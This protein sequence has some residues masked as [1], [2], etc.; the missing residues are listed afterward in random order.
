M[1]AEQIEFRMDFKVKVMDS[2]EEDGTFE[3]AFVPD[4]RRY[5]WVEQEGERFLYDKLD[6]LIFPERVWVEELSKILEGAPIYHQRQEIDSA[7][8]YVEGRIP[9]IRKVL[10]D[11]DTSIEVVDKSEDFLTSLAA[12]KLNFAILS[13]DIVSSTNRSTQITPEKY[14]RLILT[15]L[16]ELS[17]VVPKFHGHVLKYTGDGLIA[18]FPAPSFIRMNDFAIDCALTMHLLV[19][20][21]INPVLKDRGYQPID[22]RIGID[23]GE[24]SIVTIGSPDTKRHKDIIGSVISLAAKIQSVAGVGRIALG[25]TALKN[26]HTTWREICEEFESEIE[27]PYKNQAGEPYRIYRVVSHSKVG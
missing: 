14:N 13:L 27:W 15:T 1:S 25:N 9:F 16:F 10:T 11:A 3:V 18:Y 2:N 17:A 24:A 21:G 26:L 7:D 6:L 4:P 19:Y 12:D 22:I 8:S 23:S 5:E 20:K